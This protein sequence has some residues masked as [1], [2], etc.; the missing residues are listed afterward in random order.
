MARNRS[1][2]YPSISLETAIG[3]VNTI[4]ESIGTGERR[5]EEFCHSLGFTNPKSGSLLRMLAALSYYG[6]I[7]RNKERKS[8]KLTELARRIIHG[9]QGSDE[10]DEH[11][12]EACLNPPMFS[13]C[14]ET[15]GGSL[16]DDEVIKSHLILEKKFN[17]ESATSL[18]SNYK[19]SI[20]YSGLYLKKTI[21]TKK[22]A[23]P[24]SDR[25][26]NKEL[27]NPGFASL[28]GMPPL[29]TPSKSPKPG[30]QTTIDQNTKTQDSNELEYRRE[31]FSLTTGEVS[32]RYPKTLSIEDIEDIVDWFHIW[33][34][35]ERRRIS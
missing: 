10:H 7:N 16:L 29:F 24:D 15:W 8:I 4:S 14:W 31:I 30:K 26:K 23:D 12:Q 5:E 21:D 28:F 35:K 1:P 19:S 9:V 3:K 2:A 6:L 27:E 25:A 33:E 11:L 13:Y 22:Q 18:I 32:I 34:R 17:P 20:D